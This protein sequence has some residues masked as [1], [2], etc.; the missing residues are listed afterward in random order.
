MIKQTLITLAVATQVVA[1]ATA[2]MLFPGAAT[3]DAEDCGPQP[4]IP[5]PD[6]EEES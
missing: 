5:P 6:D 4:C 3:V 1:L 2:V